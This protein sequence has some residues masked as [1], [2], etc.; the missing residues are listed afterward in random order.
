MEPI[1]FVDDDVESLGIVEKVE[2]L[3]GRSL[4]RA[5]PLRL[6][7]RGIELTL[8][9]LRSLINDTANQN[10][11]AFAR[12]DNLDALG[13]LVGCQRLQPSKAQTTLRLTIEPR[14]VAT[15]IS[16]LRVANDSQ[17]TFQTNTALVINAGDSFADVTATCETAG[18]I[19]NDVLPG[20]L[21]RLVDLQPYLAD[22][23]NLTTSSGGSDLE[24]DDSYRQRIHDSINAFSTAGPADAY[25]YHAK[26]VNASI[27]DVAINSPTPGIVDVYLL[28][29]GGTLPSAELLADVQAALD[30]SNTRP[31]TDLVRVKPAEPVQF[32]SLVRKP[33]SPLPFKPPSPK[34]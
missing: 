8:I 19:G 3:L 31:L 2:E 6:F 11:L 9:H 34:P 27:T 28:C 7:L 17:L 5:D 14:E 26:S 18:T 25:A 29:Q 23:T 20:E 21:N 33:Y 15:P 22:V 12:G 16:V 1:K 4:S 32:D 30:A 24:D 13:E 10:L